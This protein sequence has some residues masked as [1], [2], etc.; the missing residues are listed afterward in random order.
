MWGRHY[1][2]NALEVKNPDGDFVLQVIVTQEYIQFAARM[3]DKNGDGVAIG[4]SKIPE[5]GTLGSVIELIGT[6]HPKLEP[7]I[8][9]IFRYPAELYIGELCRG[10]YCSKIIY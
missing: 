9:P 1:N 3:Y 2:K 5:L 6:E 4:S 10:R 8:E 7:V